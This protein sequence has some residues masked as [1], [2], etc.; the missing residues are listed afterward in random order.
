MQ[1]AP[2][3]FFDGT[4]EAALGVYAKIFGARTTLTRLGE[5]PNA[6]DVPPDRRDR[7]LHSTLT[8]PDLT[9]MAAD[10]DHVY[11]EAHRVS[12]SLAMRDTEEGRRVFE[13]LSQ[14]GRVMTPYAKQFWGATF[15]ACV[16]R[17]GVYWMVNAG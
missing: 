6:D 2:Y 9:L 1:L 15:G 7:V 13:A 11:G 14:G 10:T 5:G 4:C 12:L 3:L 16:D 8:S 17:F